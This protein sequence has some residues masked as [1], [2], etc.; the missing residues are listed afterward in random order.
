MKGLDITI[1][2]GKFVGGFLIRTIMFVLGEFL[3][4]F[5]FKYLRRRESDGELITG[6]S[7]CVDHIL[8]SC[9]ADSIITFV[10]D[11]LHVHFCGLTN[12]V[13][14]FSFQRVT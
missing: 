1:G 3:Y 10:D 12:I 4:I 9:K 7:L 11:L 6:P 2:F 8:A 13:F 5:F 14:D